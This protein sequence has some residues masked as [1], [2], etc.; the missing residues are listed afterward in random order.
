MASYLIN[1]QSKDGS[2]Q[3]YYSS[4]EPTEKDGV[5]VIQQDSGKPIIIRL[6]ILIQHSIHIVG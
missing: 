5:L 3:R 4:S 1:A 2:W 6:A